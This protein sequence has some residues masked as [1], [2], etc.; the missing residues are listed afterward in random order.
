MKLYATVASERA[1]K[2][3]GGNEYLYIKIQGAPPYSGSLL[4]VELVPDGYG[5][6]HVKKITGSVSLLRGF[7]DVANEYIETV[8]EETTKGN[9]QKG[10]CVF[11]SEDSNYCDTHGSDKAH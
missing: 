11:P 3:Q 8:M 9:K 4:D 10:E 6:A 7:I 5:H 1:S 2:G